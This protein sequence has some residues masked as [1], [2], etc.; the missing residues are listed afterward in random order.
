V[1]LLHRGERA[2]R[3]TRYTG[4]KLIWACGSGDSRHHSDYHRSARIWHDGPGRTRLEF[5]PTD[6]GPAR[7]VVENGSHRWFY[8]P[9]HRA[10]R[11]V[12]WR[13]PE[14]RLD[15][16]LRNYRVHPGSVETIAGRRAL[17]VRVEPRYP[18]NPHKQAWLD[19]ATGI[20][21]R[22]DLY[23]SS[24][25]LVSR[26]EFLKFDPERS[27][28]ATLFQVPEG[29][30]QMADAGRDRRTT[31]RIQRARLNPGVWRL[32]SAISEGRLS[33]DPALPR[34]LPPG[35]VLDRLTRTRANG[36]E[37]AWAVFT[38]GLNTLSLVQWRGPREPPDGGRERFWGP[39]DRIRWNIG[40]INAMLAGDLAP[41]ELKRIAGSIRSPRQG[42]GSLVTRK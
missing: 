35:Y 20:T 24:G 7:V 2:E 12:S 29:T 17:M 22:A 19:V 36:T 4:V 32:P 8:S 26:S 11:P 5:V 1:A 23:D 6:G 10:W 15:L 39:G 3:T 28:P 33:F 9:R 38:D 27:L 34:Y 42:A 14:P 16:L 18:G 41:A 37:V 40:P 31:E 25:R 30:P 13:P 21:L